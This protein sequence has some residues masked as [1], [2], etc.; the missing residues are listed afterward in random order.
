MIRV[1]PFR[2]REEA[3]LVDVPLGQNPE[4]LLRS[5]FPNLLEVRA[6]PHTPPV[7]RI[8]KL[9]T[10]VEAIRDVPVAALDYTLYSGGLEA[11]LGGVL[12]DTE[13][14]RDIAGIRATAKFGEEL[15]TIL[16]TVINS[17]FQNL[18]VRKRSE[19]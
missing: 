11:W 16:F 10:L 2:I 14:S 6:S 17:R 7:A 8:A 3:S 15:R 9:E 5:T 4:P 12:G 19:S 1:E 18:A 13:L